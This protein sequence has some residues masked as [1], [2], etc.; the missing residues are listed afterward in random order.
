MWSIFLWR[1][2]AKMNSK[3]SEHWKSGVCFSIWENAENM[4]SSLY[5]VVNLTSVV[6]VSFEHPLSRL[7]RTLVKR[8]MVETSLWCGIKGVLESTAIKEVFEYSKKYYVGKENCFLWLSAFLVFLMNQVWSEI[9]FGIPR[10]V[11]LT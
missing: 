6:L 4:F 11:S 5:K 2:N 9:V 3:F 1:M 8:S 7:K 10:N